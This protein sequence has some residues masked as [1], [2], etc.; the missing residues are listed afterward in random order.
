MDQDMRVHSTLTPQKGTVTW[1]TVI[2]TVLASQGGKD[3]TGFIVQ[4]HEFNGQEA[5]MIANDVG[6]RRRQNW[7]SVIREGRSYPFIIKDIRKDVY[8][9]EYTDEGKSFDT[10]KCNLTISPSMRITDKEVKKTYSQVYRML[11]Q[12]WAIMNDFYE[13]YRVYCEKKSI[14]VLEKLEVFENTFYPYMDDKCSYEE[15]H[16]HTVVTKFLEALMLDPKGIFKYAS[17]IKFEEDFIKAFVTSFKSRLQG[18]STLGKLF[19]VRSLHEDGVLQLN[20]FFDEAMKLIGKKKSVKL[21][22]FSPPFYKIVMKGNDVVTTKKQIDD[23]MTQF[24]DIVSKLGIDHFSS[25]PSVKFTHNGHTYDLDT[26]I[27]NRIYSNLVPLDD[28]GLEEFAS[29]F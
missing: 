23:F 10:K 6:K 7:S 15:R 29:Q 25:D 13:M 14:P 11:K 22:M 4:L 16:L 17:T 5:L 24:S 3:V 21:Q 18:E 2:S 12:Y 19:M 26:H 8:D 28:K 1:G 9:N 27:E 20:K